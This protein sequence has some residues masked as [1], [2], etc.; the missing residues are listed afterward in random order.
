MIKPAQNETCCA[1]C[2]PAV[3]VAK[4]WLAPPNLTPRFFEK[5]AAL[6]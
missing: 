5:L 3:Y 1:L 2:L 4:L 6:M